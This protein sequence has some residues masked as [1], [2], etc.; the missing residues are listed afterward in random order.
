MPPLPPLCLYNYYYYY[1]HLIHMDIFEF[2]EPYRVLVCRECQYCVSAT[3]GA[4]STYPLSKHKL[5]I[6]IRSGGKNGGGGAATVA[7]LLCK[8]FPTAIDQAQTLLKVPAPVSPPIPVLALRRGLKCTQCDKIIPD[9]KSGPAAM[10]THFQQHRAIRRTRG[11]DPRNLH[12]RSAHLHEDGCLSLRAS[13][14]NA[15]SL[16]TD[17]HRTSLLRIPRIKMLRLTTLP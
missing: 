2:S 16:P 13:G 6:D 12:T 4:L 1:Y 7:R 15:S 11:G 17:S 8:T 10:S 3:E 9:T 5:H 14:A